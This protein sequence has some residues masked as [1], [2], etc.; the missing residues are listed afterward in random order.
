MAT[1]QASGVFVIDVDGDAGKASVNKWII[2]GMMLP[3][4]LTVKTS[5]GWH[6]YFRVP[7]GVVVGN[8]QGTLAN[9]IDVRGDGGYVMVPPSVH[10]SGVKY[11]FL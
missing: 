9:G 10:A 11:A 2:E 7:V 6:L 8:S 3:P 5:K 4:T 1:G